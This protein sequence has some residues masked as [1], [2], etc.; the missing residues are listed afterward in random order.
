M[1]RKKELKRI[2]TLTEAGET[3]SEKGN[4]DV[5]ITIDAVHNIEK[6]NMAVL[7]TGDADFLALVSY[8]MNRKK[9]VHIFSSR[10]NVS[11]ELRTAGNGYI[12]VLTITEYIWGREI[13]NRE[14][15]LKHDIN[16]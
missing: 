8:I 7:F 2:K 4:M 12:D 9:K 13:K 10:N 11:E 16:S 1:V 3:I 5:E 14:K 6:Y 15:R